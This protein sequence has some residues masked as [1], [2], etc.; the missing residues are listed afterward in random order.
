M[1]FPLILLAL[2]LAVGSAQA[3]SLRF[4]K[5]T[6]PKALRLYV[7]ETA[8]LQVE[9]KVDTYWTIGQIFYQGKMVGQASGGTGSVVTWDGKP[10]GTVHREG[11]VH[12][13]LE[14]VE[15]SV[16]GQTTRLAEGEKLLL[17]PAAK[18]KGREFTLIKR[19]VIGPFRHEVT[20]RLAEGSDTVTAT[21]RYEALEEITPER[22]KG[23]RYVFMH[24]MPLDMTEWLSREADGTTQ[25]ASILPI[26]RTKDFVLW[27]RPVRGFA[28]YS[29]QNQVGV[30]Y[31]YPEPYAGMSHF[32][33][34]PGKDTKFRAIL[35]EK[36]A[37]AKGTKLEWAMALTPFTAPPEA[38]QERAKAVLGL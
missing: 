36:D 10:V 15:V 26:T 18:L 30:S 24:M 33:I 28:I 8:T 1:K 32:G 3:A 31:L 34:R 2:S 19:S 25:S 6:E 5:R 37:Y 7:F 35:F 4:E 14:S 22:F 27:T 23:Y 9:F 13:V 29:P 12:E 16:D 11:E 17:D 21:N 20:F 38:W